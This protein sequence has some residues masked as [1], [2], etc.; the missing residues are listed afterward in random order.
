MS[1]RLEAPQFSLSSCGFTACTMQ[2]QVPFRARIPQAASA[3]SAR[4]TRVDEAL[5]GV[6][7]G[8]RELGVHSIRR[9]YH[10]PPALRGER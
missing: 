1:R 2:G 6:P 7:G 8:R 3:A 9:K 5:D 4:V 10:C